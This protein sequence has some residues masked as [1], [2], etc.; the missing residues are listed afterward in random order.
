MHLWPIRIYQL[1]KNQIFYE[2]VYGKL[3]GFI[4]LA[5]PVLERVEDSYWTIQTNPINSSHHKN[6]LVFGESD[7]YSLNLSAEPIWSD[8]IVESLRNWQTSGQFHP[9]TCGAA[10]CRADLIPTPH[11]WICSQRNCYY[12]QRWSHIGSG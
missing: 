4:C 12:V 2:N 8:K 3:H 10:T 5:D 9:Y 6:T 11:G 1:R 7:G